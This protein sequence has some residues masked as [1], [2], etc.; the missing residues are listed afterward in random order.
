MLCKLSV[1]HYKKTA[2]LKLKT[3]GPPCWLREGEAEV[4]W[5]KVTKKTAETRGALIPMTPSGDKIQ[6]GA[7][8][9]RTDHSQRCRYYSAK[10]NGG[11][12]RMVFPSAFCT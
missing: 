12:L 8:T 11:I 10:A 2:P 5:G 9:R 1:E 7:F 3:Y 4:A 6:D